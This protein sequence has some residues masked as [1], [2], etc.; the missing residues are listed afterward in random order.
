MATVLGIVGE[1]EN[2]ANSGGT[3]NQETIFLEPP[4]PRHRYRTTHCMLERESLHDGILG[5]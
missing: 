3:H 5:E 1:S 2:C 4:T